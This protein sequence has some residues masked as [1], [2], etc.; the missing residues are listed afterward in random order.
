MFCFMCIVVLWACHSVGKQSVRSSATEVTGSCELPCGC[1]ELNLDSW[2][3][4]PVLLTTEPSL[5][6]IC[7]YLGFLKAVSGVQT[8]FPPPNSPVTLST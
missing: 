2:E 6:L 3:E 4:Q 1:W 5:H 7:C 8:S